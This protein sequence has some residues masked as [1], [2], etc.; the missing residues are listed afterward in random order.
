MA[1][2]VELLFDDQGDAAVRGLWQR[3]ADAGLPSQLRVTSATNRPH[4]TLI[5]ARRIT[6][7]VDDLLAALAPR[8][9]LPCNLGAPLIFGGG[10]F[11]MARLIVASAALLELHEEVYRRCLPFVTAPYAHSAPAQWTPH[12]TLGR[13]FT[14]DEV[15]RALA[16]VDGITEDISTT[17]RGVRRWDSDVRAERVL[18]S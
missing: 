9:P 18:V 13:R 17:V 16:E 14:P 10:R 5:A 11:T 12:A 3:L 2:S 1:H 15:G 6:A 4:V 8:F 7:D